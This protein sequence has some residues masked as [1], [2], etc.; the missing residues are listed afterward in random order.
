MNSREIL[1][2]GRGRSP[3]HRPARLDGRDR[4]PVGQHRHRLL[5]RGHT[6]R[7]S[8]APLL[9]R[10]SAR[11]LIKTS[12]ERLGVQAIFDGASMPPRI[13][14]CSRMHRS[15]Q[16]IPARCR[17]NLASDGHRSMTW[18]RYVLATC[19]SIQRK[20]QMNCFIRMIVIASAVIASAQIS[21]T[22][23]AQTRFS[24]QTEAPKLAFIHPGLLHS[25][26][27]FERMRV[28]VA[29]GKQPWIQGWQ[30]LTA[31]RHASLDWLPRPQDAV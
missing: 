25:N 23:F 15:N 29:Q 3:E 21:T 11:E 1:G 18:S 24:G 22:C 30:R 9:A 8:P 12:L 19:F 31:N 6:S 20:D 2:I 27:D 14:L 10:R 17:P 5:P 13:G 4:A 26:R 7:C 28:N 16:Q